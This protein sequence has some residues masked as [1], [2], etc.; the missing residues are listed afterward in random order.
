MPPIPPKVRALNRQSSC[1]GEFKIAI[2][3]SM[4]CKHT[5]SL[6]YWKFPIAYSGPQPLWQT[7]PETCNHPALSRGRPESLKRSVVVPMT[8]F[9]G[10]VLFPCSRHRHSSLLVSAPSAPARG[11]QSFFCSLH[12][13]IHS[14]QLPVLHNNFH[15]LLLNECSP[16][17]TLP[18]LGNN[19]TRQGC[20]D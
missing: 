6:A 19:G 12:G 1:R 11:V 7:Y 14:H 20:P 13:S 10:I 4:S 9:T 17:T 16:T 15:S 8:T 5:L 18:K 3:L 2:I